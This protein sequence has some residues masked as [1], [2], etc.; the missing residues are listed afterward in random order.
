[1]A[2]VKRPPS[3]WLLAAPLLAASSVIAHALAYRLTGRNDGVVPDDTHGYLAHL[4]VLAAPAAAVAAV[5]LTLRG[6]RTRRGERV[7]P[8][9][10]TPFALAPPL[11]FAL[12][13][14]LEHLVHTGS[15]S[16]ATAVEPTFA[17]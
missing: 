11:G 1:M 10:W 2:A 4:P 7:R 12:Q 15:L 16:S 14:H 17:I 5:A 3:V 8:L 6:V 13:E 9:P